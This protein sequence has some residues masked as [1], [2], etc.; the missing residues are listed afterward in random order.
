[1]NIVMNGS[2]VALD[3]WQR[4]ALVDAAGAVAQVQTGRLW[5]TMQDDTRDMFLAPG[6][7]MVIERNGLTLVQA[8]EPAMLVLTEPR[9]TRAVRDVLRAWASRLGRWLRPAPP[10]A[11]PYY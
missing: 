3:R 9:R 5:I 4:L 7:T 2:V 10:R 6:E 8:E 1:M 11:L